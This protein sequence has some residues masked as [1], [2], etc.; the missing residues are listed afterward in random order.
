M[1]HLYTG[2]PAN[3]PTSITL[4]DGSDA[5]SAALW[6]TPYEGLMD[7][8]AY[9]IDG[10]TAFTGAK[11]FADPIEVPSPDGIALPGG[12]QFTRVQ[13]GSFYD[14]GGANLTGALLGGGISLAAGGSIRFPLV[15]IP[16]GAIIGSVYLKI[17]PATTVAPANRIK[18]TII[19][20]NRDGTI[21]TFTGIQDTVTGASYLAAHEAVFEDFGRGVAL[22]TGSYLLEF[23]GESGANSGAVIITSPPTIL[24]S[25]AAA[26][27]GG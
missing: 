27:L 8:A 15:A 16:D 25:L 12:T 23:A 21:S 24:Y 19:R 1:T 9:V 14:T 26:D 13:S 10:A 22:S 5:P 17:D 11:T 20:T 4:P 2:N 3:N 18:C 6:N 7:R